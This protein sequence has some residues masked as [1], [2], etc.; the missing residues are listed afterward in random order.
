M[1]RC[2]TV[3]ILILGYVNSSLVWCS[4]PL[5]LHIASMCSHHFSC[6]LHNVLRLFC[7][8]GFTDI[9]NL[10]FIYI[11]RWSRSS[12]GMAFR[13]P[14]SVSLVWTSST[15]F[16][17]SLVLVLKRQSVTLAGLYSVLRAQQ[18][19]KRTLDTFLFRLYVLSQYRSPDVE[20]RYRAVSVELGANDMISITTWYLVDCGRNAA[21]VA[22]D[23]LLL[24][25]DRPKS[26]CTCWPPK[27]SH[28]FKTYRPESCLFIFA[29]FLF[30]FFWYFLNIFL[31]PVPRN[32]LLRKQNRNRFGR[33]KIHFV[34]LFWPPAA[35]TVACLPPTTVHRART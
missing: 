17:C 16:F 24:L 15:F 28:V 26:H 14:H 13:F 8:F 27:T 20:C 25:G 19:R 29:I 22:F 32:S 5:E 1:I 30:L 10:P 18:Q 11:T 31:S 33:P 7:V 23:L 12:L 4:W 3:A 34:P 35:V 9:Q 21:V 2:K 6:R